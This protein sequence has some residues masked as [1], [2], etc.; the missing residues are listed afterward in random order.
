MSGINV[1]A[2]ANA[3]GTML[4]KASRADPEHATEAA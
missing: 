2:V 1:D 3:V 4:L